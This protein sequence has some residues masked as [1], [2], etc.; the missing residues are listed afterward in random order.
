MALLIR[1][2]QLIQENQGRREIRV[3]RHHHD[4]LVILFVLVSLMDQADQ[5][6]HLV[7]KVHY[8]LCRL[9]GLVVLMVLKYLEIQQVRKVRGALVD[10]Y[11]REDLENQYLLEDQKA[12]V[13]RFLQFALDLLSHL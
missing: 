4:P 1:Y 13:H 7:Q 11:L 6:L 10:Q 2:L 9:F 5:W 12:L 8:R 3:D